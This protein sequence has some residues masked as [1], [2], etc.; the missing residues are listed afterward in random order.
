M[1]IRQF[2]KKSDLY[3][4]DITSSNFRTSPAGDKRIV[5]RLINV[6]FLLQF[7]FE[8]FVQNSIS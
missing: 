6:G 4:V 2:T 1:E 8:C 3:I 7:C 5:K